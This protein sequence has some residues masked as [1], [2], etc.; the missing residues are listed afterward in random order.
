M[1]KTTIKDTEIT[2]STSDKSGTA[3]K[4]VSPAQPVRGRPRK[5][6]T[7]EERKE[8]LRLSTQKSKSREIY[9]QLE[10]IY[11][12]QYYQNNKDK[13]KKQPKRPERQVCEICNRSILKSNIRKHEKTKKHLNNMSEVS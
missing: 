9:K 1:A 2:S 8:A 6:F 4:R 12:Q 11:N 7:E 5:Y 3:G 10:K 13:R